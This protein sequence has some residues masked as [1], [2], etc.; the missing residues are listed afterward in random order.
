MIYAF[1]KTRYPPSSALFQSCLR[2]KCR[3]AFISSCA[4]LDNKTKAAV[5]EDYLQT[6]K[7]RLY[8]AIKVGDKLARVLPAF[9]NDLLSIF[10]VTIQ[11]K[12]PE[13]DITADNGADANF[14]FSRKLKRLLQTYPCSSQVSLLSTQIYKV[15]T[16]DPCSASKM[17]VHIE[18]ILQMRQYFS[19]ILK[20]ISWIITYHYILSR[21]ICRK[22]LKLDRCDSRE[23][24]LAAKVRHGGKIDVA[25][26]LRHNRN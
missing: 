10:R 2:R 5:L 6:K 11:E 8:S 14:L 23:G 18:R 25:N 12:V 13:A 22:A 15:V 1:R 19:R 7:A 16:G 26:R 9:S 24:P 17:S 20:N 3:E 21:F 4:I